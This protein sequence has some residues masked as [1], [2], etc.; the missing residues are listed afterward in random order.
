MSKSPKMHVA[1]A[2][3]E[4]VVYV[5]AC[6]ASDRRYFVL[7]AFIEV[8]VVCTNLDSPR[9]DAKIQHKYSSFTRLEVYRCK[10]QQKAALLELM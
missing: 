3:E 4:V 7:S 9:R 1:G 6:C 2:S 10:Q 5:I 8:M